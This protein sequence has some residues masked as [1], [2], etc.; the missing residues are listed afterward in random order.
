MIMLYV[1]VGLVVSMTIA[2]ILLG[3]V[4]LRRRVSK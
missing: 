2:G 1:A 3:R 4:G